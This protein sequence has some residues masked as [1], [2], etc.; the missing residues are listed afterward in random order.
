MSLLSK[1]PIAILVAVLII[2]GSTM[3]GAR[4]SLEKES[5]QIE[6]LFY[7]GVDVD[8]YVH[9]SI[10]SQIQKRSEAAN[11]LLS[12]GRSYELAAECEDLSQAR[13]DL[14]YSGSVSGY[15]YNDTEL[16]KAFDALKT[17][18][19]KCSLSERDAK[20]VETYASTFKNAGNVI[21]NSGYNEAVR[22]FYRD[23]IYQFPAEWFY[24]NTNVDTPS[25][26]GDMW[27]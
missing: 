5:R 4:L 7:S 27:Y 19:D 12:V 23:V 17:E 26:F 16:E 24:L 13:E 14:G 10:Y 6:E 11:G 25:Y 21:A 8:G 20:A 2:L 22:E 15:Y 18:L 9:P 1:K 3:T